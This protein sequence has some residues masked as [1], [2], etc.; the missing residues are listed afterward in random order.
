LTR[1]EFQA[2]LEGRTPLRRLL[3]TLAEVASVLG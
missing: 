2:F 1:R 3:P